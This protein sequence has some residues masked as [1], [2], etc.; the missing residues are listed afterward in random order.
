MISHVQSTV[1]CFYGFYFRVLSQWLTLTLQSPVL[2]PGL[3]AETYQLHLQEERRCKSADVTVSPSGGGI[4]ELQ[5]NYLNVAIK[6]RET[7]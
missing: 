1:V 2:L 4:A 3:S 6:I 5:R 7:L